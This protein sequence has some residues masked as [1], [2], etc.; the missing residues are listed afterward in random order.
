[1][2]HGTGFPWNLPTPW[3]T[4]S[5]SLG[6]S[7]GYATWTSPSRFGPGLRQSSIGKDTGDDS[8][9]SAGTTPSDSRPR[10]L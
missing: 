2:V 8:K 5:A 9:N 4:L 6:A 3:T 10:P 1:M 7:C